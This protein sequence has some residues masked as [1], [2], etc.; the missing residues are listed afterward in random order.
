MIDPHVHL[1]DWNQREKESLEHG[2]H[3]ALRCGIDE[4]FDMPNTDPPLTNREA[5]LCRLEDAKR[6]CPEFRYHIWA[7]LTGYEEQIRSIAGV[8]HDLYPQV[9]GLKLFAGHST[10][11]MGLVEEEDQFRVY[12]ILADCRYDKVVA[13]HCEKESLLCTEKQD[14]DDF[15]SHSLVR[16]VASEVASV[17]DQ[18]R[19]SEQAHFKGHLHICHLS[20]LETLA[21]VQ[22]AK[23]EGRRISC[24]V[25]AHHAL[26]SSADAKQRYLYAKVNPPLRSETERSALFAALLEGRIDWIE[27]DHAPHSLRDKERGASGLPGFSGLLLLVKALIEKG[28][29]D[30]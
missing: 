27:S 10:G 13:I 5:I 19:L 11:N 25:T 2:M 18:L 15:S 17:A 6:A 16:P 22:K 12:Q 9:V 20:S 28:A 30:E 8:V 3:V 26:L 21:L 7:G 14:P 23:A 24:G 1:R 29:S 4:A